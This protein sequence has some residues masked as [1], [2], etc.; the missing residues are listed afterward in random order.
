MEPADRSPLIGCWP[1]VGGEPWVLHGCCW[2]ASPPVVAVLPV[3]HVAPTDDDVELI[4]LVK[5][6]DGGGDWDCRDAAVEGG[7]PPCGAD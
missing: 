1:S 2:T 5:T 7:G 4:P 3:E 6:T